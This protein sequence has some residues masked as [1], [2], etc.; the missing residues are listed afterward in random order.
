MDS[1]LSSEQVAV[2]L[3]ELPAGYLPE[4]IFLQMVRLMTV[5]VVELVPLR[6]R[7]DG[8][9][10]VL[11]VQRPQDDPYWPGMWHGPGTVLRPT[12][13]ME[14]G[15]DYGDALG[16]LLGPGGELDGVETRGEPVMVETERRRVARG[17]ELAVI[18]YVEV[19]GEPKVG[20][21]FALDD[22]YP[23]PVP[24]PG[25]VPHHNAFMRRAAARF[26]TDSYQE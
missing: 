8:T 13:K 9:P 21:F 14:S 26:L 19:T 4:D 24:A 16:R 6:R 15:H 23:A 5:A 25:I 12:D 1:S 17:D 18:F 22:T 7:S 2:Y 11:L 10:E 20:R 3:A